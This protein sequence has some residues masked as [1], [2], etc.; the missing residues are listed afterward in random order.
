MRR[1]AIPDDE[2]GVEPEIL[3]G[4]GPVQ[5]D[6][7]LDATRLRI[8]GKP[9]ALD[10]LV[11]RLAKDG[12]DLY[13]DF[14]P[15]AGLWSAVEQSRLIESLLIR[16]PIPAFY[17]DASDD[18]CWL[19]IDGL[20]RLTTLKA[21]AVDKKLK[22]KGLEYLADLNGKAFGNLPRHHQRRILETQV[23]A[24][25]L[26]EGCP[27]A[28]KHNIYRRINTGGSP[29]DAGQIRHA[30][31]QGPATRFLKLLAGSRDFKAAAGNLG[32]GLAAQ[33]CVLRF[34]AFRLTPPVDYE[35]SDLEGF[36]TEQMARL[37]A[38]DGKTLRA[39]RADL[40]R[41]LGAAQRLF[42]PWAFRRPGPPEA[43]PGPINRSLFAAWTV[44]LAALEE[45]ELEAV[46]QQ[47]D[48]LNQSFIKL[49]SNN[50]SFVESISCATGD[51]NKIKT[52]FGEI[53]K[54]IRETLQCSP[55]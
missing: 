14:Q 44:A 53:E 17:F 10:Q 3:D 26:R 45:E 7:P 48:T 39:L 19:V 13:P 2:P 18:R 47:K 51:P 46:F 16:V 43:T 35:A 23:T 12:I 15:K 28:V 5:G 24:L 32:G 52:Q 49:M 55:T 34:L 22:L 37:G 4:G 40:Q 9:L 20:Q 21:F 6:E 31:N 27:L 30:L 11:S 36:L 54:L 8:D 38:A 25:L 42:G 33:D 29:L 41:A 50:T 1:T